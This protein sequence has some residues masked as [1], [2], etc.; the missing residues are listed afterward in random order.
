MDGEG[1]GAGE[2]RKIGG[3]K[4]EVWSLIGDAVVGGG[5]WG[6]VVGGE[7]PTDR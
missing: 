7:W 5:E 6:G 4:G 3:R 2:Q 1:K